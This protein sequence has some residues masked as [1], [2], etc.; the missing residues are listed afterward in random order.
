[1][2]SSPY[3]FLRRRASD[4]ADG[5]KH[6]PPSFADARVNG[7][8]VLLDNGLVDGQTK[9]STPATGAVWHTPRL[10]M[11]LP[12]IKE[13]LV[14]R[15]ILFS[16]DAICGR[17][18]VIGYDKQFRWSWMATQLNTFVVVTDFGAEA[19]NVPA[20]EAFLADAFAYADKNYKG[21][22]RGLQSGIG[23]VAMMVS[24]NLDA[25]AISYCQELRSGKK[26]AGFTIPVVI[27]SGS[28]QMHRFGKKPM[29]G[30]IYYP[31]FEKLIDGI[32]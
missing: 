12:G 32:T 1:M 29:W 4:W 25:D 27:D 16:E 7:P 11:T 20:L 14:A 18:S 21:W 15:N 31:Y 9:A 23:V 28:G 26:W 10:A 5:N 17:P 2:G 24:S 6:A 19:A 3:D 22:P 30:R 13:E 8:L